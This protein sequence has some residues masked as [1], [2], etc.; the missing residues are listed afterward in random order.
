MK[1]QHET[2]PNPTPILR[3]GRYLLRHRPTLF[4]VH[5]IAHDGAGR[6]L[7]ATARGN[8]L[9]FSDDAAT[10]ILTIDYST[11]QILCSGFGQP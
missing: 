7:Q 11:D 3:D 1:P 6:T 9:A 10:P 8:W 2:R 4:T 5:L